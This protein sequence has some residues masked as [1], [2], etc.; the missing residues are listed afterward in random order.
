[1]VANPLQQRI[2]ELEEEKAGLRKQQ[3]QLKKEH[4]QLLKAKK[5]KEEKLGELEQRAREVQL[6]K[7]GQEI[8]LEAL[9]NMSSNKHADELRA[10]LAQQEAKFAKELAEWEA[11]V[12]EAGA[13]LS[14]VTRANTSK[15]EKVAQLTKTQ[16]KLEKDLNSTQSKM[17][18]DVGVSKERLKQ[19]REQLVSL[20]KLQAKEMEA[21]KSEINMLRR[22]GGAP[23]SRWPDVCRGSCVHSGSAPPADSA[24]GPTVIVYMRVSIFS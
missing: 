17:V 24:G 23:L 6:L 2:V 20:V 9:E 18:A 15:L 1:M 22:K 19:E 11:R 4:V 10:Q 13:E 7:F 16:H 21:L 12:A 8:D 14:K 3:R 5:A